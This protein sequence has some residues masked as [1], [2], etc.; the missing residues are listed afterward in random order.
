[1]KTPDD[2]PRV[3]R[4]LEV[5]LA[6]DD[7]ERQAYLADACGTDTE[8]RAQ[9]ERLLAARDR[10]ETFLETPAALLLDELH[11]TA[12]VSNRVVNSYQLVSLLGAG[13]MGEVYRARDTR[14]NRH[15]ALKVLPDAFAADAERLARFKR[16]A[17]LLASLNHPYIAS[18]YGFEESGTT[19]ALVLELVEG[20][21]LA[22][23]I[24]Q[25]PLP[26]DEALP[27]ARQIAEAIEAAHEQRVIHRDLKPANIKLRPDGTVKVL[28]FGL[29]KAL[30]PAGAVSDSVS[31]S[32][33]LTSPSALGHGMILGTAAYMS[34]EQ[35]RGK[36]VDK[37]CD[38]WAFGCVLYEML[39]G[40]RPFE[41]E[42]VTEILARIIEQ[43]PDLDALPVST[44][45]SIRRLLRRCLEK[46]RRNRLPD[47]GVARIEIDDAL[48]LPVDAGSRG[49][50]A[51]GVSARV[52]PAWMVIAAFIIGTVIAL[53]YSRL[54][55]AESR[56]L[57]RASIPLAERLD[58]G[59][60]QPALAIS[61]DG[62]R[63]VY[64]TLGGG[65]LRSR[66]LNYSESSVIAGTEG[67]SNPFFSPDGRSLAFFVGPALKK[68]SFDGGVVVTITT[69]PRNVGA[70]GYRGGAWADNGV[71]AFSPSTGAG[72]F[73]VSDRGGEA[74]P[75]TTLDSN[76]GET[77]HRWPHFLPGGRAILFTVKSTNLQS[78]DDAQ[79]V[80]RSLDTGEQ[81]PVAQGDSAQYLPTGHLLFAR[82]G[83]L[84][85]VR[86]DAARLAVTGAPVKVADSVTT[87]PESGGA[88]LAISRT[89][90]L[91]YAEGGSRTA[92]R[93]LLWVDRNGTA[94]PLTERQASF[95]WPRISPDGR[96][97]AVVIDAAYSKIWVLDVERGTWTRASQLAGDQDRAV[98][99][100]DGAH[101][102]F[103]GD[104]AGSGAVRV[105][106][107]R[108]DGAGSATVLFD[109]TESASPLSWSPD[110]RVLLY[111]QIGATTGQDV[112]VYSA[113]KQTSTP[114]LQTPANEWSAAFS[115]NGRWVAY[116]SDD[117]G[118]ADVY[119]RPF[120]GPGSR[121]QISIDGG[122]APVWSRDGRE[123]FFAK[124]G[125]LFATSV[126]LSGVFTS[127]PVRRLFSGPY[128]FDEVTVNYDAAPDGQ[129]FL[130][131]RS[132]IDSAPR[133]LELVLNWTEE[134]K[135]LVPTR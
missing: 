95:L 51:R 45:A 104:P 133:Q 126:T 38:I 131:P 132:R 102:S 72:L 9:I 67:A 83:S 29:A 56:L 27:V 99:M 60:Q 119:V 73:V 63:V 10:T 12:D 87:H 68:V 61:P 81:H 103:G 134:L 89:G 34:P 5:A 32:P 108:S 57:V 50:A 115:P 40:R 7:V 105:Y 14:L 96:R 6:C 18:I 98:W 124:E 116:V 2:W 130:V 24:A 25:G 77:A 75:L 121:T 90:T 125:A 35:A 44:P 92:E 66:L 111:R 43:E 13:G 47:I 107:D 28:D 41:G 69:L 120:P 15:V 37:R 100:P 117:S 55:A 113:D 79:I 26:L 8:L 123:L 74:K 19:H 11:P 76:A 59:V 65:S 17:Q 21:T 129:H 112:W 93:P 46:D 109:R 3:K 49:A 22:D 71:I 23:R 94:R 128:S 122:T 39:T 33:T 84:Y 110:G 135:R 58:F 127:G 42:D 85:A 88:Q 80:V 97:I 70:Q 54:P 106:S 86:F 16:E 20:P 64:R 1:M 114:L 31:M 62:T 78:F 53:M 118:R 4:L 82:A 36:T 91:V 48:A 52:S 101:L 30:E